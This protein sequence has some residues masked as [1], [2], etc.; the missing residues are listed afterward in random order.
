MVYWD[1]VIEL[2]LMKKEKCFA[3]AGELQIEIDENQSFCCSSMKIMI[4]LL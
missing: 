2:L 3:I 1:M 4:I